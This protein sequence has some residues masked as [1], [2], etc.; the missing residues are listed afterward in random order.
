MVSPVVGCTIGD[1]ICCKSRLE[2]PDLVF[3]LFGVQMSGE[4]AQTHSDKK[5]IASCDTNVLLRTPP[6]IGTK[7][8]QGMFVG[9][10]CARV[11]RCKRGDRWGEAMG[12]GVIV[13]GGSTTEI[14]LLG[15]VGVMAG[16]LPGML[17][18]V[19]RE[20]VRLVIFITRFAVGLG[21]VMMGGAF[22]IRSND[23]SV[24]TL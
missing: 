21:A 15:N 4:F 24:C 8:M 11:L 19:R 7:R 6:L 20:C 16:T 3:N 17:F 5:I 14:Y 22:V 1:A 10:K 2:G 23:T 12:G 18:R 9:A 13:W